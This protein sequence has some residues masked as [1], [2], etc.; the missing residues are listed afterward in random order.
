MAEAAQSWPTVTEPPRSPEEEHAARRSNG[1][2]ED[3]AEDYDLSEPPP[4]PSVRADPGVEAMALLQA[5][6]G[7]RP[8]DDQ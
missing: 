1:P 2:I 5:E 3:S 4:D 8:L 6:L 7:A